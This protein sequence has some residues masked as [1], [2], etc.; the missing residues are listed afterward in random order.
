MSDDMGSFR[1]DVEI[2][3]LPRWFSDNRATSYCSRRALWKG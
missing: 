3:N 1:V 2:E